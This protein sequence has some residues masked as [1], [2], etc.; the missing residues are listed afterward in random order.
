[1]TISTYLLRVLVALG[2]GMGLLFTS[3][4]LVAIVDVR[5]LKDKIVNIAFCTFLVIFT[6]SAY[7]S[8]YMK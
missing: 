3:I 8:W 7:L 4:S 2:F 6:A 5:P 1:M